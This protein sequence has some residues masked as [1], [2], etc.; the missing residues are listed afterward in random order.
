MTEEE[1][2]EDSLSEPPRGATPVTSPGVVASS[3]G[4][5]HADGSHAHGGAGHG[6][7][8]GEH[9][10]HGHGVSCE[11][12]FVAS[13]EVEG[14]QGQELGEN[15]GDGKVLFFDC[16]SGI[17]GNMV[18]AALLD[19][20]VPRRVVDDAVKRL[21]LD[22]AELLVESGYAG[23]IGST[24]VRVVSRRP[25][26]T[27]T[28]AD[29][30]AL[31]DSAPLDEG[32][33]QLSQRIF[34]RLAA[35]ESE[36][37]RVDKK[38]VHFHEVG[39]VDAIVDI[40]GAAS[41]LSYLGARVVASPV[42]LGRGHVHCQHGVLPLPAPA[43]LLCLRNVPTVSAPVEKELV[44]P[45]GAAILAEVAEEFVDW[46]AVR[47]ERVGW[48]AGTRG[49]PDRPNALRAVLGREELGREGEGPALS[50]VQLEANIDDMTGEVASYALSRLLE[51]GALDAW[52][53]PILMKKGRPGMILGALAPRQLEGSLS[54]IF[55]SETTTIGVRKK[56]VSRRTLSRRLGE[57]STRFGP[58]PVK[59][60]G[61]SGLKPEVDACIEIARRQ[62]V[63][64][65][66]VLEEALAQG[67][68]S[69]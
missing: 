55:L 27:R 61:T 31:V 64:L 56:L 63:A 38:D 1:K 19:L 24:H 14:A 33:R 53:V 49:L 41:L 40:V 60:S 30:V 28:Y 17:A 47:M 57:V 45:T 7:A 42:P 25:P 36:V 48:G 32:A 8:T 54:E 3:S 5:S 4:H 50:H 13:K 59:Y 9:T 65:R 52:I 68:S 67:R 66:E 34:S 69:R 23:A 62:G 29:I 46:P 6:Q 2:R 43:A 39:A 35:A 37:H 12:G 11:V 44:T 21:G 22:E 15:A 51:A 26:K 58:V 18:I 16:Q 20:G 10:Q